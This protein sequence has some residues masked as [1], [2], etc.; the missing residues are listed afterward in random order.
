MEEEQSNFLL[1]GIYS[2]TNSDYEDYKNK[3]ESS[4]H[5]GNIQSNNNLDEISQ[6]SININDFSNIFES[7]IERILLAPTEGFSNDSDEDKQIF[8]PEKP[9]FSQI[10]KDNFE[11]KFLKNILE[12]GNL[13]V[14]LQ[15]YLNFLN[16]L[17]SEDIKYIE[18]EVYDCL[19]LDQNNHIQFLAKKRKRRNEQKIHSKLDIDNMMRQIKTS[20]INKI[21]EF[22]NKSFNS[23]LLNNDFSETKNVL[24]TES[25]RKFIFSPIYK[26]FEGKVSSK[27][28]KLKNK[29]EYNKEKISELRKKFPD[30][31]NYLDKNFHEYLN[32]IRYGEEETHHNL[33]T[34]EQNLPKI[35]QLI[36]EIE[37]KYKKEK[38]EELEELSKY[39]IKFILLLYNYERYYFAKSKRRHQRKEPPEKKFE[40]KNI[41]FD[42][43]T[44]IS[45]LNDSFSDLQNKYNFKKDTQNIYDDLSERDESFEN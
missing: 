36:E 32:I 6:N 31:K 40:I 45:N 11:P 27:Y 17:S 43:S 42:Q 21:R 18:E 34:I 14:Y 4:S 15:P 39:I 29:E 16:N 28:K 30:S 10:S 41:D 5:N 22:F 2:Q 23:E 7:Q 3:D 8:F 38:P 1:D 9:D 19:K 20:I 12:I 24:D 37:N 35:E 25:N 44:N 26:I 33:K 13:K